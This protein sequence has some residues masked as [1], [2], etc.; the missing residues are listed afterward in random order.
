[1][2]QI[3]LL[4]QF[5]A[6]LDGK[7]VKLAP[8]LRR[9]L[10]HL[11]I[12]N[13]AHSREA[14]IAFLWPAEDDASRF[15][16]LR[17]LLTRLRQALGE[18]YAK[19]SRL[20]GT[21][22]IRFV[23][24]PGD[25]VDVLE[26]DAIDPATADLPTLTRLAHTYALP[27]DDIADVFSYARRDRLVKS[28]TAVLA[29]LCR[30]HREHND[31][32]LARRFVL[33]WQDALPSDED[34]YIEE[35]H[36]CALGGDEDAVIETLERCQTMTQMAPSPRLWKAHE[37]FVALARNQLD[38]GL[39]PANNLPLFETAFVGRARELGRIQQALLTRDTGNGTDGPGRG[40]GAIVTLLG[41]GGMGKTRLAVA[42]ATRVLRRFTD[43]AHFV[44]VEGVTDIAT[45]WQRIADAIG[46]R[47]CTGDSTRPETQLLRALQDRN[48]LLILDGFE[49]ALA[50]DLER[51]SVSWLDAVARTCKDVRI[52]VTSRQRCMSTH[53]R[54]IEISG[55]GAAARPL[56]E[57]DHTD[58]SDAAMP[59]SDDAIDLFLSIVARHSSEAQDREQVAHIC[60]LVGGMP[61]AIEIV[62][63]WVRLASCQRIAE[64]IAHERLL[65]DDPKQ[66]QAI[67]DSTSGMVDEAGKSTR[68]IR[69]CLEYT[70]RQLMPHER[71]LFV[72]LSQF[73][74]DFST[75]SARFVGDV[76][77]S[78]LLGLMDKSVIQK[79]RPNRL[80]MHELVRM[81]GRQKGLENGL[82]A[83]TEQSVAEAG[84]RI[85]DFFFEAVQKP[86]VDLDAFGDDWHN[87][88]GAIRFAARDQR[89][90]TM[91]EIVDAL[92]EPW[93]LRSRYV[94]AHRAH[95]LAENAARALGDRKA[96]VRALRWRGRMQLAQGRYAQATGLFEEALSHAY[97]EED[98]REI[99]VVRY[100]QAWCAIEMGDGQHADR[101][102]SESLALL[103]QGPDIYASD[104]GQV[105]SLAARRS[106]DRG[107]VAGAIKA[108]T[109][110]IALL[111]PIDATAHLAHAY[112]WMAEA[113]Q[114]GKNFAESRRWVERAMETGARAKDM[115]TIASCKYVAARLHYLMEAELESGLAL[116]LQA[117]KAFLHV[118]VPKSAAYALDLAGLLHARLG[119]MNE[120][121]ALISQSLKHVLELDD[122]WAAVNLRM[123][124]GDVEDSCGNRD[125]ARELWRVALQSAQALDHPYCDQLTKRLT[126]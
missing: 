98:E 97:S 91:L 116:A 1:M 74:G 37:R 124:L 56:P 84:R 19:P 99:G 70:W 65:I 72:M 29:Q 9:V 57:Q 81:F 33:Q 76:T 17:S 125:I 7:P 2:L 42:V 114:V 75:D 115:F 4:G 18:S 12:N 40:T 119:N 16:D 39:I 5:Q 93:Y 83:D 85:T 64:D 11:V 15:E 120:A 28:Y 47:F 36:I 34:A 96:L 118:G 24:Q 103:Q 30:H 62:A 53:E 111:E 87:F 59:S 61:L 69:A 3:R 50:H 92:S 22:I 109:N 78:A 80:W 23:L 123:H 95:A 94:D 67:A 73:E 71:R 49:H 110:A 82:G 54:V 106:L 52:L 8:R 51:E 108:A 105:W 86:N 21:D 35:M 38:Q 26:F 101:L 41:T 112:K 43:G 100:D 44:S 126:V 20:L 63:T 10:T 89:W 77:G 122:T 66:D 79:M 60:K 32:A 14:L 121:R 31:F 46:Y 58:G 68:G 27:A 102:I 88:I 25:S 48:D 104:A 45:L 107:D 90:R 117:N 6:L 113:H 13:R 55:L